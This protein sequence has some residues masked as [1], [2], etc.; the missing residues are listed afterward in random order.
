MPFG[1]RGSEEVS[2]K[3]IHIAVYSMYI[4]YMV[5]RRSIIHHRSRRS[6]RYGVRLAKNEISFKGENGSPL[7]SPFQMRAKMP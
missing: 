3:E 6:Y 4:Q 5:A 2:G 1:K 7:L